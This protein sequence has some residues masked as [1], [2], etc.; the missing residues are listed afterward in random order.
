MNHTSIKSVRWTAGLLSG[1]LLL[2][3]LRS[4]AIEIPLESLTPVRIGFVDLQKVFDTY[5][6]KSFAEG[7]LLRE[8]EKRRRDLG[9]R[10]AEINAYR[11][12][13]AAD[14][15]ALQKALTGQAVQVPINVIPTPAPTPTP[16][17]AAPATAQVKTSTTP[18]PVEPYP[19]EDP[20]AGLPGH[21][22]SGTAAAQLPG[23]QQGKQV[24]I[25]DTLAAS[26]GPVIL[27]QEAQTALQTRIADNK[28]AL[29]K[30]VVSFRAFRTNAIGDMKALQSE[31]TY[32]VMAKIYAIL[33]QLA[34]DE[35][36]TVVI[37]KAYVLYGED[38]VD[39]SEKLISRLQAETPL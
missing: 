10:Q 35:N 27:N 3:G 14:E 37:D 30:A 19:T 39:L 34:R 32:G 9:R 4:L 23:V 8:V 24:L 5:P 12:Q 2:L 29:E 20:L 13:I 33:Q 11:G 22:T 28:K 15:A 17:P 6:E 1:A 7:D 25:L 21:E 36:V 26:T 38:T 31:K 18:A 16:A